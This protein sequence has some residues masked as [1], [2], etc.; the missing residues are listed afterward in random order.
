MRWLNVSHCYFTP[1]RFSKAI[2]VHFART[3]QL[4]I[5]LLPSGAIVDQD[6]ISKRGLE[7][8]YFNLSAS[9]AKAM[10]NG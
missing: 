8:G 10:T 4:A 1:M 6:R 3:K 2:G 5:P 7:C 9:F